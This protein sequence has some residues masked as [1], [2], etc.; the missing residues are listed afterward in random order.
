M[1][2]FDYI[3]QNPPYSGDLHLEFLKTGVDMLNEDGQMVII[4]PAT[5][6]I[7]LRDNGKVIKYSEIKEQLNKHVKSITIE[8]LN[9]AFEIS[10]Q[11]PLAITHIDLSNIYDTIEFNYCGEKYIKDNLYDCNHIGSKLIFDN[12]VKKISILSDCVENYI[13]KKNNKPS[14]NSAYLRYGN[15]MLNTIGKRHF[16][17]NNY[18]SCTIN[19]NIGRYF[20]TYLVVG[21]EKDV[22]NEIPKSEKGNNCDCIYYDKF[23][24]FEDNKRIL[25]NYKDFIWNTK[26]AK[27]IIIA[28]TFDRNNGS[29]KYIPW[30]DFSKKWTDEMINVYFN[31]TDDEIKMINNVCERFEA[32]H[33]T[34]KRFIMGPKNN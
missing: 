22:L 1:P 25:E 16:D 12:I 15:Y 28:T 30:L 13:L 3:V 27:F 14:E 7:N 26:F 29:M 23:D 5:W 20:N 33:P 32:N 4:E 19:T 2:K 11:T 6:L 9:K 31:F 8:N 24:N 17:D 21:A 10:N 34:F 18:L